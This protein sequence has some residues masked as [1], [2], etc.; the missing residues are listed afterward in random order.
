MELELSEL[1]AFLGN[2]PTHSPSHSLRMGEAVFIRT[3]THHYTGR[4][5]AITDSDIVL[6]DAAWIAEDGRFY[7]ALR[8]G[9]LSEVEPYPHGCIVSRGAL[10]DVSPWKHELPKEQL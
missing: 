10:L 4:I 6:E 2:A 9:K 3:V 1:K 7:N 5:T 8:D